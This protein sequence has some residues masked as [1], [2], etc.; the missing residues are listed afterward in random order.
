MG[1]AMSLHLDFHVSV[2]WF[3]CEIYSM[4]SC[5]WTIDSQLVVLFGEL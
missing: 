1:K 3:E 5:V 2:L 4:G